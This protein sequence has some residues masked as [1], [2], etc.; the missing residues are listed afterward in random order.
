[1]GE[2]F[3]AALEL[4]RPTRAALPI[5][6]IAVASIVVATLVIAALE[7]WTAIPD[8]SA[9]YLVAVVI[10]GSIGGTWP[11]LATAIGSFVVYDILF[12]EPRFS[13]VVADPVE[14]LNLVLVLIVALADRA[15]G[16]TRTG[17]GDRSRPT[18]DRGHGVLRHQPPHRDRRFDGF[19]P[20]G[21]RGAPDP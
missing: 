18:S 17:T 15:V 10:A 3:A 13:L 21:D 14:L 12:T 5:G 6:A 20:A 8:A 19:D 4:P 1:M 11:A 16:G 2:R 9:V 7:N